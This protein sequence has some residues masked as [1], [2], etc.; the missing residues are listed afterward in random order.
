MSVQRLVR[1]V[2]F[3]QQEF[4]RHRGDQFAQAARA[5][6][7]DRTAESDA[8][9][10]FPQLLR[11]LDAAGKAVHHAAQAADTAQRRD[12][13]VDGAPRVQD[14]RQVE[15]ARQFELT[16]KIPALGFGIETLDVEIQA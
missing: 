7:R 11:L 9:S 16:A 3:E 5:R 15:L 10:Q 4:Q 6:I 1:R 8:E 13:F 14:N 12:Y 2:G